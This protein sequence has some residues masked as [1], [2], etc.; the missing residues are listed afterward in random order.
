[1]TCAGFVLVGGNSSRMGR[2][3]ALLP[4]GGTTLAQHIAGLVKDVA[5]S[6]TLVGDPG[7]YSGLGFP[8]VADSIAGCGPIGGVITAL[9]A[10]STDW[11]LVV[12]CDMPAVSVELLRRIVGQI[13]TSAPGCIVPRGPTGAEPLCAAYHRDCL[14]VFEKAVSEGRFKMREAVRQ[15]PIEWLDADADALTNLNTPQ[16]FDAFSRR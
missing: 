4:W 12:G 11:V 9:Q 6:A 16:E 10:A 14:P 5:G 2:D 7:R 1:M 15:V 3:K 8:V 13:H